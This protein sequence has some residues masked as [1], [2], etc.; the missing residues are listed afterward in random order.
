VTTELTTKAEQ[1]TRLARLVE[2]VLLDRVAEHATAEH[3]QAD[4]KGPP[5]ATVVWTK[6]A[7]PGGA[8]IAGRP[9][10][11]REG[12]LHLVTAGAAQVLVDAGYAQVRESLTVPAWQQ[13]EVAEELRAVAGELQAT[14]DELDRWSLGQP[15]DPV[16]G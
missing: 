13:P 5:L 4:P 1:A 9:Y 10:E 6:D 8:L 2:T 16:E 3:K 7:P 11:G 14:A 12:E 15:Q